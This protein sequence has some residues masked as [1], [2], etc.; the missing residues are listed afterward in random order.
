MAEVA[1]LLM[2]RQP[3]WHKEFRMGRWVDGWMGEWVGVIANLI[4]S[5]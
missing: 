4:Q 3:S 2:E 5:F 1:H